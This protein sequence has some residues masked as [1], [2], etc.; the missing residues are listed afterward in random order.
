MLQITTSGVA[1]GKHESTWLVVVVEAGRARPPRQGLDSCGPTWRSVVADGWLP[2]LDDHGTGVVG[3]GGVAPP[4]L[5]DETGVLLVEL[6]PV[7][8]S[9]GFEPTSPESQSGALPL[10]YDH[11]ALRAIRTRNLWLRRPA[12]VLRAARAYR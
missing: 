10:S 8:W 11:S 2:G 1:R 3:K 4:A 5:V 7:G 12:L 6:L 9:T